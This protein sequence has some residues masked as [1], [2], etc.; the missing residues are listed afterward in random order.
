MDALNFELRLQILNYGSIINHGIT[1]H[2]YLYVLIHV[3]LN[4]S[5]YASPDYMYL[6]LLLIMLMNPFVRRAVTS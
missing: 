3:K 6:R 4:I 1:M 5:R 2:E